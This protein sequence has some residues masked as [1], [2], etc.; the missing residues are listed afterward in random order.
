MLTATARR[1][2]LALMRD[3]T[4][5]PELRFAAAHVALVLEHL[6]RE[7]TAA[8]DIRALQT[9]FVEVNDG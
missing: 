5:D 3:A 8:L 4:Q 7:Q 6:D 9:T 1:V 2:C